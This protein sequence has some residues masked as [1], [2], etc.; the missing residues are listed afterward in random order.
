[1]ASCTTSKWVSTAPQIKLTVTESS[2]TGGSV[3]YNWKLEYIASS[4][5][6]TNQNRSY[7]AKINGTRVTESNA[8]YNIDGKKG[9]YTI[10]SGS[11]TINKTHSSQTIS[12]SCSMDFNLT[13]SNVYAGTKSAN[14]KFTVGAKT[15]YSVTYDAN[16]GSGAPGAQT[17]WYGEA[18][19]LSSKVP[20][21]SGWTFIGWGTTASDT[22][23]NYAKGSSYTSN[24]AIKLYAIWNKTLKL[25]FNAS[26]GSDAPSA[27]SATIYNS[28]TSYKFTIPSKKPTRTGYS[29]LGWS[30]TSGATSASYSA[31][32]TISISSNTTLYAVWKANTYTVTYNA[33]GGEFASDSVTTQTKT[34]GQTMSISASQPSKANYNFLGWS[35][36][37]TA[38]SATYDNGSSFTT[39]DNTTLYAVWE[40]GYT[41]PRISNVQ[42]D[43]CTS[44][45]S[46][47]DDGTCALI[48][49]DW[50]CDYATSSVIVSYSGGSKT[51]TGYS[52][53]SGSC[54]NV[55]VGSTGTFSIENSYILTITVSDNTDYNYTTVK[56]PSM[57]FMIDLLNGGKG[58]SVGK[59]ASKANTFD[60]G[61]ATNIDSTLKVAGKTTLNG[62]LDVIGDIETNLDVVASKGYFSN[63]IVDYTLSA[64][65]V[66]AGHITASQS[67]SAANNISAGGSLTVTG[68]VTVDEDVHVTGTIFPYAKMGFSAPYSTAT[69]FFQKWKDGA[70]HDMVTGSNDGLSSGFGWAG[71]SS[72]ATVTTVRGRTCRYSNSS[73]TSTM[74][75]KNLKKDFEEFTDK[76]DIFFDNLK[77]T[78]FKYILGS[79]GR[80]HFGYITQEVIEALENAGLT[81]KD[82]AGVNIIPINCRETETDPDTGELIDIEDS[83]D[84]YLLDNDI[85]ELY[86]LI[87]T[88]FISMN[89]WQVQKLKKRVAEQDERIAK[90]EELITQLISNKEV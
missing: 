71:S 51:I 30:K 65:T 77:P 37:S 36:S 61:W 29:F 41:M 63:A 56:L 40:L 54:K 75:D 76:Y 59:A 15:S 87:Y 7:T 20:T 62:G 21:R 38:T 26:S 11:I 17:K 66:S 42:V 1:M 73:G 82:F 27:L 13:W 33:N 88:E 50:S 35:T 39:N 72:Y 89:T 18:L 24:T 53:T 49:F 28:T 2:N 3:K 60:V 85:N 79:S 57:E 70:N 83:A 34:Y 14:G 58:V 32:S 67:I 16:G 80:K 23:S 64:G 46:P 78:I 84:N 19:T 44:S 68:D 43:R 6:N 25:S 81:T 22:S 4:E 12:Y 52:G 90:L 55:V 31:G 45:G 9:T 8:T 5:A 47:A 48:S 86:N 69:G 10:D 74:S